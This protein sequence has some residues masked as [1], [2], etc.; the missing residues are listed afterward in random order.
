MKKEKLISI[1]FKT[2][3]KESVVSML[4]D[5]LKG[6]IG[7]YIEPL[8]QDDVLSVFINTECDVDNTPAQ[9]LNRTHQPCII[10]CLGRKTAADH[11]RH[12]ENRDPENLT[13]FHCCFSN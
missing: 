11:D 4:V 9:F 3:I 5:F 12:H 2:S 8:F 10:S 6:L 7:N 1:I 13:E